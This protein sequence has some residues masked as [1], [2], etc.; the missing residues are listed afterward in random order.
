[1]TSQD[2]FSP[3]VIKRFI[4]IAAI[5]TFAMFTFW[6]VLKPGFLDR[7][8]GDYEVQ[9]GD[10]LLKERKF[11]EAMERFDAA[12][13]LA[14]NHRGA[15]MGRAIAFM[16]TG[17]S[18]EAEAEFNYIINYMK[19]NAA[20]NDPTDVAVLAGAYANRGILNDREGRYEK[21]LS[22]YVYALRTDEGAVSGPDIF[23][24]I[25]HNAKP[26]TVRDRAKYLYEQLQLP[27]DE[28]LLRVPELDAQ[29]RMHRP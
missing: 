7:P 10:N 18:L 4:V 17:R 1:M 27:E 5:A 25:L 12:L 2:Y 3:N 29:Q 9:Q 13:E 28:R 8:P 16:E 23:H 6:I 14:P 26:S 20:P 22:D 24:K 19:E 15:M 11:D 21:A